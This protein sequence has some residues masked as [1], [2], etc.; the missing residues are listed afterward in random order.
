MFEAGKFRHN[1][2]RR[3][4]SP[5]QLDQMLR[6]TL[7]RRWLALAGLLVLIAAVVVWSAIAT[8][9]TTLKGP[10]YLLPQGGLREVQAPAAGV[11]QQI[12]TA[13]GS[14]VVARQTVGAI[15]DG[16]GKVRPVIAPETGVLTE[17]DTV[18]HA[19]VSAGQRLG[20]VQ[21]VGWPLVVYAYVP[22][23]V[24]ADLRPGTDVHVDF[25]AGIGQAFGYARGHVTSVSQFP[26]TGERLRFILQD[27]S[28]IQSVSKLG[29]SNE[30][31]VTMDQSASTPSGLVWG[32]G[33]GPGG[34]LPA[35]LP[36]KVTFIVGSHH[37]IDNVL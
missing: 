30:V 7:P 4:T 36:S 21:P 11:V 32:S 17:A 19:Y 5:E 14:H 22:A 34:P 8:V 24:A 27:S 16:S 23:D 28:T 1:A 3:M 2:L 12:T 35:G 15:R 13:T 18:A 10:G 31:V 20:L 29:P 37:P 33:T 25:G 26:A 6:I 9:P